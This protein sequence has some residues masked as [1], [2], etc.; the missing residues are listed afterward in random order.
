MKKHRNILWLLLVALAL[1][2]CRRSMTPPKTTSPELQLYYIGSEAGRDSAQ[3]SA[4]VALEWFFEQTGMKLRSDG[5]VQLVDTVPQLPDSIKA[6]IYL[7][8]TDSDVCGGAP[9]GGQIGYLHINVPGCRTPWG[10]WSAGQPDYQRWQ[11]ATYRERSLIHEIL[12][13]LGAVPR[14]APAWCGADH[15]CDDEDDIM[16]DGRISGKSDNFDVDRA[17][18]YA[19]LQTS[20]YIH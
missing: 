7:E 2:S 18:Y 9:V 20:P 12:H 15:V 5:S 6:I 14:S 19:I 17:D 1:V 4:S 10:L 3:I 16:S 13:L 8:E 11:F